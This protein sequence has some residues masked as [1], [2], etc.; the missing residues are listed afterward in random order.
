MGKRPSFW[1]VLVFFLFVF[2]GCNY[3]GANKNH[4]N[5]FPKPS[6]EKLVVKQKLDSL[7]HLHFNRN[8][9]SAIFYS[10]K[11]IH[12]FDS[13]GSQAMIFESYFYL[14]EIYLHSK[15]NDFLATCYFSEGLKIMIK[16]NIDF[17]INPFY[18]IDIGNLMHRHRLYYQ[19]MDK[20][21]IAATLAQKSGHK[22]AEAVACNNIGLC[23]QK[24]NQ[25]DSAS[26]YLRKG[27]RLRK[28][29]MPL[30]EA[31]NYLYL[32][33]IYLDVPNSD[34]VLLYYSAITNSLRKQKF[35]PGNIV[36]M[37][38]ENAI[39][40][41]DEIEIEKEN[42]LA[43]YYELMNENPDKAINCYKKARSQALQ[44]QN[45]QLY[46][47]ISLGYAKLLIKTNQKQ[48]ATEVLEASFKF[49][50]QTGNIDKALEICRMMSGVYSKMNQINQEKL[51]LQKTIQYS[52]SLIKMEFSNQL[53]NEKIL[54][55]TAQ[56]EH[57]LNN[58]RIILQKNKTIIKSQKT[59]IIVLILSVIVI[60]TFLGI[61]VVQRKKLNAAYHAL[62]ARTMQIID[63]ERPKTK[64][65]NQQIIADQTSTLL[66]QLENLMLEE[67]LYLDPEISIT[68]LAKQLSTNEKYLSQLF[69]QQLNSTFN[70]Y[71]NSLRIIEACRL[72]TTTVKPIKSV[73][74]IAED[75]GFR[76]RSAFYNAFK[77]YTGV[78]PAFFIKSNMGK[79]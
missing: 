19:A 30:L 54:L 44:K 60:S 13:T 41:A 31:Q 9:D 53:M 6:N 47:E 52:D 35:A 51:W 77:K 10:E 57:E 62:V 72:M 11:L 67:R 7:I 15:P 12:Y 3:F 37:P 36:G 78:T 29:L 23:Y 16:N 21:R 1:V 71:I 18:L 74:Q 55:F 2:I 5:Q 26:F 48:S 61:V 17:D 79:N 76:S 70:D 8:P 69:N 25:Y 75:A 73:D 59:S 49:Y 66:H 32:S 33:K 42:I 14:S 27:L 45:L 65:Q 63:T 40:L 43:G 58:Y 22:Y 34:S 64:Q 24:I 38:I 50:Q 56:T 28:N 20:Y 4:E 46:N 68:K 39:N